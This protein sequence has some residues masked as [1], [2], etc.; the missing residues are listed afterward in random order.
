M[1][2][3]INQYD[4]NRINRINQH[5]SNMIN[6]INQHDSNMINQYSAVIQHRDQCSKKNNMY[7]RGQK[8]ND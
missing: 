6:C 8:S 1:S 5:D 2:A 7:H 3:Q 4:N